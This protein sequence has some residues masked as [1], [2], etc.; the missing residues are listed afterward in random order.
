MQTL[1]SIRVTR[2]EGSSRVKKKLFSD[3]EILVTIINIL[4]NIQ[5]RHLTMNIS[6]LPRSDEERFQ[7]SSHCA[8]IKRP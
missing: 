8:S 3:N 7:K 2:L 4:V 1:I 6:K 5:T